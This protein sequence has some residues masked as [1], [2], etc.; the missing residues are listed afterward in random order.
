[1]AKSPQYGA[2]VPTTNIWDPTTLYT[3]NLSSPEELRELLVRMYQ[4]LNNMANILNI[5]DTGMYQVSEFVN[6]QLFYS[7]PN[8]NSTTANQPA[9]RQV[10][11]KVIN[12]GAL[13]N[14][15][16]KSVPHNIIC[17]AATTFTRIYGCA[18]NPSTAYIPL[19]YSSSA[20]VAHNIE[21]FADTT[22]VNVTTGSNYSTYTTTYIILEY[23][24]T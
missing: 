8:F 2:F 1:M 23:L 12:F 14:A 20:D 19:P 18:T 24:Q 13:P 3:A 16:T 10:L 7:N 6:G 9:L 22:N 5:K 21:L 15:G 11:R 4:N 17:T